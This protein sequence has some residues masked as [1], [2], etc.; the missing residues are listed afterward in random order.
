MNF[1]KIMPFNDFSH[2][3]KCTSP[4]DL[5]GDPCCRRSAVP[6]QLSADY[7]FG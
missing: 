1:L 2:F 5:T 4:R 6:A 7:A 3:A